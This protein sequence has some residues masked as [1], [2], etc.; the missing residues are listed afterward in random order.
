MN[1]CG[2]QLNSCQ[3]NPPPVDI[4]YAAQHMNNDRTQV[5]PGTST[6]PRTLGVQGIIS[7]C[8]ILRANCKGTS[9]EHGSDTGDTRR[10]CR[11]LRIV[12]VA[13]QHSHTATHLNK[14]ST[15]RFFEHLSHIGLLYHL[16][17]K[18]REVKRS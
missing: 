9:A 15:S 12:I 11:S 14:L 5:W 7:Y 18:V 3:L 10:Q 17:K 13:R 6:L 8:H 16:V 2:I 1:S 4:P